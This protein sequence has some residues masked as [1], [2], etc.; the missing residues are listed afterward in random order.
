MQE[1][2]MNNDSVMTML[3]DGIITSRF[4]LMLFAIGLMGY[5]IL[6][7]SRTAK[8][9][10]KKL[11]TTFEASEEVVDANEEEDDDAAS[12]PMRLS[13]VLQVMETCDKDAHLLATAQMDGFLEDYPQHAFTMCDVQI[14]LGFCSKSFADKGLADRLLNS[15]EATEESAVLFA[16]LRFYVDSKQSEKACDVF[17]LNYST[18]FD[19]EL[20]EDLESRLL[21]AASECGRNSLAQHLLQTSQTDY[22]TPVVTIQ[23]WWRRSSAKV[24]EARVE[25]MGDVLTRLSSMFNE[26]YPFEE[27]SDGESTCFLGDESDGEDSETDSSWEED[28]RS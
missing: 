11:D 23:Q 24:V 1:V 27:H 25:N 12:A 2:M 26:R 9:F 13:R 8:K 3:L 10:H 18:F 19:A 28:F 17:E 22:A 21:A 15:M 5:F 20:D 6:F 16:F 7:S 4:D 14:I